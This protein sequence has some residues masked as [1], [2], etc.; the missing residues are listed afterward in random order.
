MANIYL[1]I[2]E[3]CSQLQIARSTLDRWR[4]LGE[5]PKS[6][7]LPNGKIRFRQSDVEEWLNE[8]S[9]KPKKR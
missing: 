6:F 2:T 3:L 4:T 7:R 5:A 1:S 8:L 9:D